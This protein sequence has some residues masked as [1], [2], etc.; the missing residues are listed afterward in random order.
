MKRQIEYLPEKDEIY[1]IDQFNDKKDKHEKI[2]FDHFSDIMFGFSKIDKTYLDEDLGKM[3]ATYIKKL[4][5]DVPITFSEREYYKN[6]EDIFRQHDLRENTKDPEMNTLF[7]NLANENNVIPKHIITS[8]IESFE[9]PIDIKS[10]FEPIGNK[11]KLEFEDFCLL[12]K[13]RGPEENILIKTFYSTFFCLSDQ[14]ENFKVANDSFPIK[15][16]PH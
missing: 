4:G 16:V 14:G 5:T 15:Y 8:V 6:I 10:F 12:F 9:L 1:F 3:K 13:K 7:E 11:E 2:S